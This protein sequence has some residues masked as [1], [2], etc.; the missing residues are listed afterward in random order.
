MGRKGFSPTTIVLVVVM[1]GALFFVARQVNGVPPGPPEP[2][3]PVTT[4][5]PPVDPKAMHAAHEAEMKTHQ[6][7]MIAHMGK[8]GKP[9]AP[10]VRP[11]VDPN[12][13]DVTPNYWHQNDM[14]ANGTKHLDAEIKKFNDSAPPPRMVPPGAHPHPGMPTGSPVPMPAPAG[15]GE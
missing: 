3:K 15:A 11:G 9:V 12:A 2:V 1:M 4:I 14:G 8:N 13:I 10:V 7:E 6:A 5:A